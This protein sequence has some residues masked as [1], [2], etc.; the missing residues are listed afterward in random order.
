M[1]AV[2]TPTRRF[3]G[4]DLT[5]SS[6]AR[7]TYEDFTWLV[8]D[9]LLGTRLG[10]YDMATIRHGISVDFLM[11]PKRPEKYRNLAAAYNQAAQRAIEIGANYLVSLQDYIWV[12]HDGL[13]MFLEVHDVVPKALV[14][15]LTSHSEKPTKDDIANIKGAYTIFKEPLTSKPEG[16]S[17]HD[18]RE[19]D[20][21]PEENIKTIKCKPDHWEA[22][23]ASI[24]ME[25]IRD[26][27][28]WDEDYDIGVAYENMDF[29]FRAFK[30]GATCVLDKR[31]HAISLPHRTYFEGEEEEIKEHSNRIM[32]EQKC[33]I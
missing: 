3:G 7:Q 22:N 29:A 31:N 27:L 16:I 6:L 1:I 28:R 32:Y 26:G 20:L 4:L 2:F 10:V 12:P 9:E 11:T 19:L 8:Q 5:I 14:T 23:W 18:V 13:E 24:D 21:Y 17:W 15:G 33:M 25:V 30:A